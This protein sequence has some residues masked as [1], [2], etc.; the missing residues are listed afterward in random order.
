[1]HEIDAIYLQQYSSNFRTAT[2]VPKSTDSVIKYNTK[3]SI[4]EKPTSQDR[5]RTF[6]KITNYL[7]EISD[8]PI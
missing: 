6:P 3:Q 7:D 5:T 2:N 1:M 4:L 8:E